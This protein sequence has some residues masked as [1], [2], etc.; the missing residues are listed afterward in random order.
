[1]LRYRDRD[2]N[3]MGKIL[4]IHFSTVY[5]V[6]Q[7]KYDTSHSGSQKLPGVDVLLEKCGKT[8]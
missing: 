2:Y 5:Y 4:S 8:H 7:S 6:I 1:M 3:K